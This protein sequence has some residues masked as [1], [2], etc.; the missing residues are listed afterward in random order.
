MEWRR[1]SAA[2]DEGEEGPKAML[3]DEEEVVYEPFPQEGKE[4]VH[5]HG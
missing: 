1:K 4:V 5:V 3:P 2:V